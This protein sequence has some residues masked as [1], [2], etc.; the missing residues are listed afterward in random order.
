MEAGSVRIREAKENGEWFKTR[1]I[2]RE[3]AVPPYLKEALE[4][5]RKALD[6]FHNLASSYRRQFVGWIDSAKKEETRKRRIAESI[7]LLEQNRELGMK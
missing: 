2:R 3:L 7:E 5:N 4:K 1:A 6:N